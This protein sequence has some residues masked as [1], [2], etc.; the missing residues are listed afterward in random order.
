MQTAHVRRAV[1]ADQAALL[2][3]MQAHYGSAD[4]SGGAAEMARLLT[5]PG[6]RP[7]FALLA[8]ARGSADATNTGAQRLYDRLDVPR[9]K[10]CFYRL[11]GEVLARF[12]GA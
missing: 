12:A 4:P 9:Q 10:K 11:D 2:S 5:R 6:E 3:D 8:E 1:P 7:P